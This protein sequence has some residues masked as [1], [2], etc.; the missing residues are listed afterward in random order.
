MFLSALKW[1]RSLVSRGILQAPLHRRGKTD[2]KIQGSAIS[3]GKQNLGKRK[4]RLVLTDLSL[5][6]FPVSLSPPCIS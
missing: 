5:R 1:D 2:D 3:L 4:G 6:L